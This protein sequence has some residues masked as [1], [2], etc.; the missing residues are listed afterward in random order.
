[1]I[2]E[3]KGNIV[4]YEDKN[5]N[6]ELRA[7]IE[8]DTIWATQEQIAKLFESSKQTVS[9][10]TTRIFNEGE[11]NEKS[12]VKECL[13]T[14][15]DSKQYLTKFY[16]LDAIIAVGYRVNS[17][18][19]TKFRIWATRILRE[20]LVKGFNLDKRTINRS[21]ENVEDLQKALAFMGSENI[22]GALK[23]KLTLKVT[24]N[25]LP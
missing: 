18:K 21:T 14:A 13:T 19:A 10:H 25:L 24:K 12:V 20:Y 23:G 22:R 5:G 2:Q 6:V 4:I 15:K 7:D 17:K 1:M 3:N 8:K 16:N 9:R 11:L